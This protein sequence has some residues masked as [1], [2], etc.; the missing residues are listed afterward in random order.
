MFKIISNLELELGMFLVMMLEDGKVGS[1]ELDI[2][3][4]WQALDPWVRGRGGEGGEWRER[5]GNG[6]RGEEE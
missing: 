5:E 6:G 4:D 3:T 1:V 2:L